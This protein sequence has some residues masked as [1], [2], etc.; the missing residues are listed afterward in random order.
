V[1]QLDGSRDLSVNDAGDLV[2]KNGSSELR[3]KRPVAYQPTA[4]GNKLIEASYRIRG[5]RVSFEM[6][7]YDPRLPLVIDPVLTYST[8]LAGSSADTVAG[9]AVDQAGNAYVA[10]TTNSP[11]FPTQGGYACNTCTH[12][13]NLFVTK[14]DP[15]GANLVYSSYIGGSGGDQAFG[16][17]I[18]GS[19]NLL[20]AGLTG[21][22]DFPLVNS[23]TT[24]SGRNVSY[25]FVLSVSAN[26]SQLNYSSL[27][28]QVMFG[29]SF[30]GPPFAFTVDALGNA[31][32]ASR[33]YDP[34]YPITPGTLGTTVAGYPYDE[35]FVSKLGPTGSLS[36]STV[37]PGT[38]SYANYTFD[39]NDFIP[40]ALAVDNTGSLHIAGKA[41]PGLPTT[42]GTISPAFAGDP[43]NP[44][45]YVGF[46]L[47]INP[48][49]SSVAL[50]TYV[51]FADFVHVMTLHGSGIYIGGSTGSGQFPA[52][53][54]GSSPLAPPDTLA[55]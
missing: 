47:K 38:L 32:V 40:Y 17:G 22:P 2:V 31:Y 41:G 55:T 52:T 34:A 53:L 48:T 4:Q 46:L 29:G 18:D 45:S 12:H 35:L 28:G 19:G 11:D 23:Y 51:P 13:A 49:A 6:A 50:G 5:S 20:V 9:I 30:P 37:I 36:Y 27:L 33:T 42:S 43:T 21:S 26:G 54:L 15:S 7:A 3:F 24:F 8:W 1:L 14:L 16:V 25:D 10:G 44:S 39:S